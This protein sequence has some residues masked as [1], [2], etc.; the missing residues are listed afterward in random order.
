MKNSN[1]NVA[2]IEEVRKNKIMKDVDDDKKQKHDALM[3]EFK[4][5][6]RKMFASQSEAP[7]ATDKDNTSAESSLA[8]EKVEMPRST[9]STIIF[10]GV[11]SQ[12]LFSLSAIRGF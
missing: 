8:S 2:Q 12:Y 1:F 10:A 5:A 11:V 9:G 7:A 6:H 3:D 4:K